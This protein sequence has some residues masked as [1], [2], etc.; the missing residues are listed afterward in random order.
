MISYLAVAVISAAT[1]AY[2][3]LLVRLFAIVQWHHFAF[4]A[5]SIA[6]LGFGASGTWL[7]LWQRWAG[8]RFTPIFAASAALFALSAPASFLAAQALPFNA[9]AIVWDLGQLLYLLAMYLLL[10]VPFFCGA[11]CVGLAFVCYGDK[12]E[13]LYASSI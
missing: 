5:I 7:A 1:L 11:T 8:S 2:E 10:V 6:L 13:R 12:V 9:L 4:M 3:V